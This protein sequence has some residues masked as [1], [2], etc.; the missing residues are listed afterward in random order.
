MWRRNAT[1]PRLL[2]LGSLASAAAFGFSVEPHSTECFEERA[3]ESDHVQGQWSLVLPST[4]HDAQSKP[5]PPHIEG[6]RVKVT[7]P[8][9]DKVYHSED[10]PEGSFDY[11]AT[12]EGVYVVC[13][14]NDRKETAEVTAKISVGDPP[15]LIQLAKTEHLT[16]IEERIKNVC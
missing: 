11:Y 13:F 3:S 7:S 8:Q 4:T 15:D 12:V 2:L 5:L 1:L 14:S 16:P 10:E 9:G 6:W